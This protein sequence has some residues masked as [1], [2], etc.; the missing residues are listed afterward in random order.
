[1]SMSL[2]L[3]MINANNGH[4]IDQ[5]M[6]G[7]LNSLGGVLGAVS[8]Q[9]VT[10]QEEIIYSSSVISITHEERKSLLLCR[11]NQAH[12]QRDYTVPSSDLILASC[13]VYLLNC[14]SSVSEVTNSN[15]CL[16]PTFPLDLFS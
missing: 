8:S 10:R 14:T 13:N 9:R 1:M 12:W 6:R 7:Q 15:L 11:L 5:S 4:S 3:T 16:L 2:S